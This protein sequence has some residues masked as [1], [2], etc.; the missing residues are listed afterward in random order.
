MVTCL[1]KNEEWIDVFSFCT[2]VSFTGCM[3]SKIGI[4]IENCN[5][6]QQLW[7]RARDQ[8]INLFMWCRKNKFGWS[9]PYP[10]PQ[11]YPA[12]IKILTYKT[13]L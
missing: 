8:V 4:Q 9:Y 5:Q 10:T 11:Y 7:D 13:L 6:S 12:V 1:S 2:P 3:V